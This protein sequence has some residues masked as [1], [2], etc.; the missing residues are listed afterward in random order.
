MQIL[1]KLWLLKNGYINMVFFVLYSWI[2]AKIVGMKIQDYPGMN[3]GK[4]EV[5]KFYSRFNGNRQYSCKWYTYWNWIRYCH[6]HSSLFFLSR[7]PSLI[8]QSLSNSNAELFQ[9]MDDDLILTAFLIQERMK[10]KES[11]WYPWFQVRN[12][13]VYKM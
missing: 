10:E 5:L 9:Q 3:R 13:H 11:Y 7:S 2:L 4:K 1:L 6:V 12:L 8:L